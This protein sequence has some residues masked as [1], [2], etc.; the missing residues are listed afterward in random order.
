MT[1]VAYVFWKL[2][3]VKDTVTQIFKERRIIAPF[4]GQ[5]VKCC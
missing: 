5:H 1:V 2:P 4:Y 3:T